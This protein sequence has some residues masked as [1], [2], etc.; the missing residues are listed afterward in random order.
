MA[1]RQGEMEVESA[2]LQ[3]RVLE[4]SLALLQADGNRSD[5]RS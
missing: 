3:V 2:R 5:G 4:T 1:T